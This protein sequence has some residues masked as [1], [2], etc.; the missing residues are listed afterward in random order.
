MPWCQPNLGPINVMGAGGGRGRGLWGGKAE[1]REKERGVPEYY[2]NIKISPV[3][4][5]G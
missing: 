1:E 5:E 4:L 2:G 3:L